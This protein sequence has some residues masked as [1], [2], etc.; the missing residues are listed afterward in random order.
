MT[1]TKLLIAAALA[2]P[3][4]A[5]AMPAQ[6]QVAGIATADPVD[7]VGHSKAYLAANQQIGTTF[8]DNLDKLTAKQA[9]RQ[10]LLAQLDTNGD[11][12]I[13]DAEQAKAIA[14]KN[15]AWTQV[16]ALEQEINN[17]GTPPVRA[18]AFAIEMILQRYAEAQKNVIAAKK[19]SVILTPESFVYAPESTDVTGAITTALDGLVPTVPITAPNDWRPSRETLA[20]QERLQQLSAQ[21][22]QLAALQA[23]QQ[24][25]GGAK[26]A[27]PAGTKPAGTAP[28]TR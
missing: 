12:Q 24:A 23:R 3:A 1:T 11:K 7:A 5:I 22:A 25:A 21:Y 2:A 13:D 19:I 14:A 26:P 17:L 18:Q 10:K 16:Q 6:A 28:V 8:K 20:V 9:E 4:L 27:A 15:P